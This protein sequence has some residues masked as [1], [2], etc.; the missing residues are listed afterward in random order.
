LVA[1]NRKQLHRDL[2]NNVSANGR[3]VQIRQVPVLTTTTFYALENRF[4]RVY[5]EQF[6][7]AFFAK[8]YEPPL[9][10]IGHRAVSVKVIN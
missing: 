2:P 10:I 9:L 8:H 3:N 5:R 1:E 7:A 4:V 6:T